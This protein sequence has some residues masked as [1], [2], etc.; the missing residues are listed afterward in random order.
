MNVPQY[1]TVLEYLTLL[2]WS[3]IFLGLGALCVAVNMTCLLL[4]GRTHAKRLEKLPVVEFRPAGEA[5]A[6]Y[7]NT[8]RSW[9]T[10]PPMESVCR[11]TLRDTAPLQRI[12]GRHRRALRDDKQVE[13]NASAVSPGRALWKHPGEA[14]A[15]NNLPDRTAVNEDRR[16]GVF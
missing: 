2:L 14:V 10:E 3:F 4:R 11:A 5:L 16:Q 7:A 6:G 15:A 1:L 8:R 13:R 12:T 9:R